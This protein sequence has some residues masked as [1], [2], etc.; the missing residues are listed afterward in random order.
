[1]TLTGSIGCERRVVVLNSALHPPSCQN[2]SGSLR[3]DGTASELWNEKCS[4]GGSV[5]NDK[6]L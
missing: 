4:G 6:L 3:R 5:P 1:M 2:L